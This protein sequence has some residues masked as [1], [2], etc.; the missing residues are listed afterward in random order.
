MKRF[1]IALCA[2]LLSMGAFAQNDKADNIVGTY[3]CGTG[4]EAYKV[5]IVKLADGTYRGAVC[6]TA[7]LYDDNGK[8]RTDVKNPDKTLRNVPMDK[9]VVFSGLQYDARKQHW[10]GT[11]IYDPNR[12]LRVKMTAKFEQTGTLVVRGTVLGIGESVTWV[13]QD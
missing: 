3:L 13:K 6:W 2:F 1:L 4:K 7:H 8:V 10:S 12:G 11:K 5:Q 9:V